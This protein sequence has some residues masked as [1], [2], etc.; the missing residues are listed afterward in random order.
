MG[1]RIGYHSSSHLTQLTVVCKSTPTYC[2]LV[3]NGDGC[4]ITWAL[5]IL[6]QIILFPFSLPP[7]Y[8]PSLSPFFILPFLS[9][10]LLPSRPSFI[11][12]FLL[13]S[14]PTS[15]PSFLPF[16]S[17][18]FS[19]LPFFF[20]LHSLSLSLFFSISLLDAGISPQ[21][22]HMQS[23][24]STTETHPQPHKVLFSKEAIWPWLIKGF[25]EKSFGS[26]LLAESKSYT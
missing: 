17:P 3:R 8:S 6:L 2:Y 16:F 21:A 23:T 18:Y 13:L 7:C 11:L 24:W 26:S 14:F 25:E 19:L 10:F 15:L 9:P 4:I 20:L 22:S 5:G 12:P 1:L